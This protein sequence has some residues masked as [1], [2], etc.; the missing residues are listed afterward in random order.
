[1]TVESYTEETGAEDLSIDDSP[2]IKALRT[3]IR[4]LEK[5]VKAAPS[6]ESI[7]AEIRTELERTK[8]ISEQLIAL[9]HPVGMAAVLQGRLGDAD[10]T[11]DAVAEALRGIGYQVEIGGA[12]EGNGEQPAAVNSQ[13]AQV[14]N[15]SA[16]VSTASASTPA[17]FLDRINS[18]K[19]SAE[20]NAIMAEA[21]ELQQS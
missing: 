5:A 2:I 1:L 12:P 9:G 7:E 21:G 6:R 18:A 14:A 10:V 20:L 3:Q 19:D 17:S 15:L 11:A 8:A 4:D 16:Q 13:L